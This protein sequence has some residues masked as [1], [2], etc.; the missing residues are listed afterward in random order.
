MAS[1]YSTKRATNI[2]GFTDGVTNH[3]KFPMKKKSGLLIM[4]TTLLFR[5]CIVLSLVQL[6][7][8]DILLSFSI[9]LSNELITESEKSLCSK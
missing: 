2:K 1:H 8:P 4:E 6:F 9:I 5:L 3:L 7:F